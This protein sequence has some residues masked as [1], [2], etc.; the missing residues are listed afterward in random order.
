ML[1]VLLLIILKISLVCKRI[2]MR[3]VTPVR[4]L[5]LMFF[6]HFFCSENVLMIVL[7]MVFRAKLL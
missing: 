3:M 1:L 2:R 4:I 7:L 6:L 5:K